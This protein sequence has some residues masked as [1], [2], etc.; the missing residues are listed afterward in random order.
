MCSSVAISATGQWLPDRQ[1]FMKVLHGPV[2]GEVSSR[3]TVTSQD[4]LGGEQPLQADRAP[5]VD[6]S[7]ADAYLRSYQ[8]KRQQGRIEKVVL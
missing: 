8:P 7:C 4:P 3:V 5:G 1:V 2:L 6:T